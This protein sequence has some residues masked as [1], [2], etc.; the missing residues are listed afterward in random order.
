MR[1][2]SQLMD[3]RGRKA[4]ITGGAGHI[5]LA[6]GE[7]LVELGAKVAVLDRDPAA[8]ASRARALNRLRPGAAVPVECDLS[9]EGATR[10]AARRARS[11]LGGVD[12]L[13]HTAAYVGT[14]RHPGWAVPFPK[15]TT[16]AFE[17]AMRVNL[18]AAFTLTHELRASLGRTGRGSVILIAS[19]YGVVGPDLS[20]YEGTTMAN[21]AGYGASKG[22]VIQ[23][24]RYLS[25]VLAPRVRVNALSPGGVLR[26]Q[27]K[28]F[29]DRYARKTPLAR[30]AREE[31]FKGA[32]A[33]LA[34]DLSAY[35]T[36]HNL[37]VDG[38]WT[39]W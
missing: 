7:A 9:D 14:T 21:P 11:L 15:Q 10:R 1:R 6:A 16:D 5:G 3:M 37:L 31:D 30:M 33:Y 29:V 26:G 23:L 39:A 2:I 4:L 35:T 27:P 38:G 36:G 20:L 13:I 18:T 19:T 17:S 32:V 12:V 24:T 28:V 25:T 34:S 22:G 8:C